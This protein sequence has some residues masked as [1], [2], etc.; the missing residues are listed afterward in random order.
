MV[1]MDSKRLRRIAWSVGL[2]VALVVAWMLVPAYVLVL[3]TSL[4]RDTKRSVALG[5]LRSVLVVYLAVAAVAPV[6]GGV[7]IALVLRAR[8][9]GRSRPV[10]AR[11]GLLCTAMLVCVIVIEAVAGSYRAWAFRPITGLPRLFA[12]GMDAT[13]GD[14]NEVRILVLG[15]SSARGDP[16]HQWLSVAHILAWQIERAN[17]GRKVRVE[18][19]AIGG[20]AL[21]PMLD[22]LAKQ[23]RRPDAVLVFSGHN[24]FQARF[25]WDRTVNYYNDDLTHRPEPSLVERLGGWTPLCRMVRDA[26]NRQYLDVPPPTI[27][28]RELVDR[29][30]FTLAEYAELRD[31]F[32]Q[33]LEEIAAWCDRAGALPIFILPA[34]N[35]AGFEPD[36]S[37][38]SPETPR[39]LREAF[40][41]EFTAAKRSETMNATAA[42]AS[43]RTLIERQPGFA[44]THF[45]LA[46]LL[47]A[48]G[49]VEDARRH[50][51]IARDRDGLPMKCPSDFQAAYRAAATRHNLILVDAPTVLT[52]LSP[53]GLLDDYVF[54][55]A[56]H[57]TFR[58]YL[59][60]AQDAL[61][62]LKKRQV[63]GLECL[64]TAAIDPA[65]C[66]RHF[67][68]SPQRWQA[69]CGYSAMFWRRI[70]T[71]RYDPSERLAKSIRNVQA[72]EK[73]A[74]GLPPD[75][76]GVPGLGL[77]LDLREASK[78]ELGPQQE[79]GS[80]K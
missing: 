57:T 20:A 72:G 80:V 68:M 52:R 5:F 55:D 14:P 11:V 23:T 39:L 28:T 10:L 19:E 75:D 26:I 17:P 50:Y 49:Q 74:L 8:R 2:I 16:Y 3:S 51:Q 59:A 40:A 41:R 48:R 64:G 47:Q 44:E 79:K 42:E 67:G 43:D 18:M 27:V 30:A 31:L 46:R 69:V 36:R 21:S 24:E 62:Q 37:V 66:A 65:D 54:H 77:R 53:T 45:R 61:D 60:L 6:V 35:D 7:A 63:F 1:R 38:L 13:P 29:P 73:V 9:K 71:I 15:E 76:A 12:P 33:E 56:H 32:A 70:A 78:A 22:V 34:A 25:N 58:G 4:S